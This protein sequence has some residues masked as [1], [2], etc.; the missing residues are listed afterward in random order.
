MTYKSITIILIFNKYHQFRM[1]HKF[2]GTNF[3]E[4]KYIGVG[5]SS[6]FIIWDPM[7]S[8][9]SSNKSLYIIWEYRRWVRTI[10]SFILY[11]MP[12]QIILVAY[13]RRIHRGLRGLKLLEDDKICYYK[14]QKLVLILIN[15]QNE[16]L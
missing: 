15:F 4:E 1:Q 7:R 12:L 13:F 6:H 10:F 16:L 8:L 9:K 5:H 11:A 14:Y 2:I 3:T